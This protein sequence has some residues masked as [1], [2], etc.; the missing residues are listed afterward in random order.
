MHIFEVKALSCSHCIQTVTRALRTLDPDA[1]VEIDLATRRVR[2]RATA[3][4]ASLRAALA[5]AGYPAT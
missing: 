5:A 1:L 2:V 4:E 3:S